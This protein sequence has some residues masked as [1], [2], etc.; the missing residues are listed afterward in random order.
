MI[1]PNNTVAVFQLIPMP[2]HI[3]KTTQFIRR[4]KI[5]GST[6]HKNSNATIDEK[7]DKYL[8][9]IKR[10]KKIDLEA[11][12]SKQNNILLDLLRCQSK[13][14]MSTTRMK[15]NSSN[16]NNNNCNNVEKLYTK[17]HCSVMGTGNFNGRKN[18]SEELKCFL[19]CVIIE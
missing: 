12:G 4:M 11:I 2:S 1:L 18:C 6:I 19:D 17:C 10:K 9:L 7:C 3:K 14:Q 8:K 15:N 16:D 5:E 13:Q